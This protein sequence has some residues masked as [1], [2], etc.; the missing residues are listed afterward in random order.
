MDRSSFKLRIAEYAGRVVPTTRK[1][2]LG[3]V[4]QLANRLFTRALGEVVV[5]YDSLSFAGSL[6]HRGYLDSLRRGQPPETRELGLFLAALRPGATAVDVGAYLGLYTCLAARQVGPEGG[7]IAFEPDP[8]TCRYLRRNVSANGLAERV[9]VEEAVVAD[10]SGTASLFFHRHPDMNSIRP[11]DGS[12][13][14]IR[15]EAVRLDDALDGC[16]G[17]SV[18]KIDA[19]GAELRI[20]EGARETIRRHRPALLVECYPDALEEMGAS[21]KDLCRW[22][23]GAGYRVARVTGREGDLAPVPPWPDALANLWCLP[24]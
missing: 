24:S 13:R 15:C 18:V 20:L 21:A 16:Q 2:G 22:L 19:E 17:V 5:G 8:D 9:R 3:P 4:N 14:T 6:R 7:V 10:R 1:L 11:N 23:A 12:S